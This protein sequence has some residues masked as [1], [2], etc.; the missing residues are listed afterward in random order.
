MSNWFDVLFKEHNERGEAMFAFSRKQ[1]EEAFEG[2][3][4]VTWEQFQKEWVSV[5]DSGLHVKRS[6]HAGFTERIETDFA[7]WEARQ[8]E[9]CVQF[10]HKDYWDRPCYEVVS[11]DDGAPVKVGQILKDVE[12]LPIGEAVSLHD[13][14]QG[15]PN[16]ALDIRVRYVEP[17]TVT[18]N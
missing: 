3:L 1:V 7:A 13:H 18:A 8:P 12:L 10:K 14:Y 16:S 17:T 6:A 4:A 5:G 2:D 15:E 9:V 11:H